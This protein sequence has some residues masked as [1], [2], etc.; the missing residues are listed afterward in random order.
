METVLQLR[1]R[2][3]PFFVHNLFAQFG[4]STGKYASVGSNVHNIGN[5]DNSWQQ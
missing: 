5:Y 2:Y 3:I 1:S 4:N